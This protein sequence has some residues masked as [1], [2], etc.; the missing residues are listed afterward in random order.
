MNLS[1]TVLDEVTPTTAREEAVVVDPDVASTSAQP[2]PKKGILKPSSSH[3]NFPRKGVVERN[4]SGQLFQS[5][6]SSDQFSDRPTTKIPKLTLTWSEKNAGLNDNFSIGHV[7]VNRPLIAVTIYGDT[8]SDEAT[9]ETDDIQIPVIVPLSAA[10]HLQPSRPT[11]RLNAKIPFNTHAIGDSER[12]TAILCDDEENEE[13]MKPEEDEIQR[14]DEDEAVEAEDDQ[15]LDNE[16]HSTATIGNSHIAGKWW[17]GKSTK[18]I[19]HCAKWGCSHNHHDKEST[20]NGS[21]YLTPTQQRFKEIHHLRKQLKLALSQLEDKDIHLNELREQLRNLESV[22]NSNNSINGEHQLVLQNKE[23]AEDYEREKQKLID[24]HEVGNFDRNETKIRVRQLI[25]EAVDARAEM[26]KLQ[27]ALKQLEKVKAEVKVKDAETMTEPADEILDSIHPEPPRISSSFPPSPQ[28]EQAP[29]SRFMQ[30][31]RD[32]LLQ[33][34]AY[35]NEAMVWRTKAVQLEIVLKDQL[36][37]S[38]QGI[39]PEL[40]RCRIE[41]ERLRMY[42]KNIE[43]NGSNQVMTDSGFEASVNATLSTTISDCYSQQCVELKRKLME[44]NHRLLEKIEERTLRLHD[45]EEDMN[46]LRNTIR[47]MEEKNQKNFLA[48]E[49]MSKEIEER[50]AEV[51]AA[52]I[53]VVRLQSEVAVRTKAICYLEERHQVY[54]NAIL[55]HHLVIKDESTADW[56]RGFSD[57]RY[58]VNVSKRVQTDLTQETLRNNEVNFISLSD[59]LKILEKEFSSKENNMLERFQEIEKDLLAKSSLVSS[60][61]SQ[62]EEADREAARSSE[63]H[64]KERDVF[65][66]KMYELG[67]IAENVP[68]LQFEIEKLQQERNLLEYQLK[69]AKEEYDAGLDMALAESLKKYQQQSNYWAEKISAVNANNESLRNEN[70][71][72][73]RSIEELKLRTQVQKADMAKRLTSSIDH[74]NRNTRDVQVDV[75]PR[76]VSKYVACRPNARHKTTDIEKGDLFDEVEERLKLCQGELNTTRRQ[77]AVLQQKLV[78]SVQT[79]IDDISPNEKFAPMKILTTDKELNSS[80][81][82]NS[83]TMLDSLREQVEELEKQNRDLGVQLL[84]A[85]TEKQNLIDSQ[86]QQISQHISEFNIFRKELDQELGRYENERQRMKAHIAVLEKIKLERDRLFEILK[87]TTVLDGKCS[88]YPY[89]HARWL[90]VPHLIRMST[91]GSSS[92]EMASLRE[93]NSILAGDNVRLNRELIALKHSVESSK[94]DSTS[95]PHSKNE[96]VA[97][98]KLSTVNERSPTFDLAANLMQLE[99]QNPSSSRI[100][101]LEQLK[102]ALK[103]SKEQQKALKEQLDRVTLDFQDAC[104]ELDLYKHEPRDDAL[105]YSRDIRL[106]RS[107]SFDEIGRATVDLDEY[108]RWKEK[109]GTMF[110]EL[111]RIR[112]EYHTCDGERRELRMQLV[113]LRGELGLAQCQVAEML[114]NQRRKQG[115]SMSNISAASVNCGSSS[116]LAKR[117]KIKSRLL[118]GRRPSEFWDAVDSTSGIFFTACTSVSSLNDGLFSISEPELV[119]SRF[120]DVRKYRFCSCVHRDFC[121]SPAHCQDSRRSSSAHYEGTQRTLQEHDE[122]IKEADQMQITSLRETEHQQKDISDK[123]CWKTHSES[124]LSSCFPEGQT[125]KDKQKLEILEKQI[126]EKRKKQTMMKEPTRQYDYDARISIPSQENETFARNIDEMAIK[127]QKIYSKT[128]KKDT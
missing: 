64:Q 125:S 86:Q 123:D 93:R 14:E 107:R 26:T 108:L 124:K 35:G 85:E 82:M 120:E 46:L 19:P 10:Q 29:D 52:N 40:E 70:I 21:K 18:N 128:F 105:K 47:S 20:D 6:Q 127:N 41:N 48:M 113:M 91:V 49:Q 23:L 56:E 84:G 88:N 2:M 74:L 126:K 37:K 12:Q 112:K 83:E 118:Q 72:L 87:D 67:L 106:P 68:V 28:M 61:T 51:Q 39:S 9:T 94:R 60:L 100:T 1:V 98:Q 55:E 32:L 66:V 104:R 59:K 78:D 80:V 13:E 111:N 27:M 89:S 44:E 115:R 116:T 109:A 114:S 53:A 34:Q 38:Q 4:V 42:I 103:K 63:L 75:H 95:H 117:E 119:T 77:V 45:Y 50:T 58:V 92:I 15:L 73:K 7:S 97:S 96:T 76:V 3:G 62:L 24:K 16:L 25:Q 69:N 43:G 79:K 121:L 5:K 81:I 110:R 102:I 54:R 65:Q 57:P 22:V 122:S 8:T 17:F 30:I 33:L 71:A 90:S 31:P 36:L 99:E 11:V 101:E